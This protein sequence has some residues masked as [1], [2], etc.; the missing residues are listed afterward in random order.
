MAELS[1]GSV[2][3][4]MGGYA[5]L[6]AIRAPGH[7]PHDDEHGHRNQPDDEKRLER[8]DDPARNRDGKPDG[9]DHAEDCPDDPAHAP[10]MHPAPLK[11]GGCAGLTACP[12][13][14]RRLAR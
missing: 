1:P 8:G 5:L 7:E 9:E 13:V 14:L 12:A 2:I 10:S 4:Q 3:A 6:V 11:G